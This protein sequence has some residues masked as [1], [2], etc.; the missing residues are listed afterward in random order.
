MCD[1]AFQLLPNTLDGIEGDSSYSIL[2][3][4]GWPTSGMEIKSSNPG[5]FYV[6]GSPSRPSSTSP[7]SD[8]SDISSILQYL[9]STRT[10]SHT[11]TSPTGSCSSTGGGIYSTASASHGLGLQ[12][13]YQLQYPSIQQSQQLQ[14]QQL[15][16]QQ[17]QGMKKLQRP[18]SANCPLTKDVSYMQQQ[19]HRFLEEHCQQ[20]LHAAHAQQDPYLRDYSSHNPQQLFNRSPLYESPS[21]INSR[22]LDGSRYTQPQS[23][24]HNQ[25]PYNVG[26]SRPTFL[27]SPGQGQGQ[28]FDGYQQVPANT[29]QY[30]SLSAGYRGQSPPELQQQRTQALQQQVQSTAQQQVQAYQQ[31]Q[32][33][34]SQQQSQSAVQ[35]QVAA[36]HQ[37]EHGGSQSTS[38]PRSQPSCV[39]SIPPFPM[40]PPGYS[41]Q[42]VN[43]HAKYQRQHSGGSDKS[44]SQNSSIK[45]PQ[46]KQQQ[47]QNQQIQKLQQQQQQQQQQHLQEQNQQQIQQHLKEQQNQQLQ[48]KQQLQQQQILQDQQ[49]QHLQQQLQLLQQQQQQLQQKQQQLQEEDQQLQRQLS[50]GQQL[51]QEQQ[52]IIEMLPQEATT[53]Q[54][55]NVVANHPVLPQYPG[56]VANQLMIQKTG[57]QPVLRRS[58]EKLERMPR[59]LSQPDLTKLLDAVDPPKLLALSKTDLDLPDR[60]CT[61]APPGALCANQHQPAQLQ[62]TIQQQ[63]PEPR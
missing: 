3:R 1:I 32:L 44:Q 30:Q 42:P 50:G 29:S 45:K 52:Q 48:E 28:N 37:S 55:Q 43:K 8:V 41:L 26:S 51:Q 7:Q 5:T 21:F 34:A 16:Q 53:Q 12:Q 13:A 24:P 22:L 35:Q 63:L 33:Q 47:Q 23:L 11:G 39:T 2:E 49:N 4:L 57:D 58:F 9:S 15:H 18:K 20:Y 10:P 17:G 31:Q 38:P 14:A 61:P 36:K 56:V 40:P 27:F 19:A 59:T 6:T 62:Q 60:P 25:I 54:Q 46:Q